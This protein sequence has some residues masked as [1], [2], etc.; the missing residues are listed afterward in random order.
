MYVE[1]QVSYTIYYYTHRHTHTHH[2]SLSLFIGRGKW[3]MGKWRYK[4]VWGDVLTGRPPWMY[5]Y[6]TVHVWIH[7]SN[8]FSDSFFLRIFFDYVILAFSLYS[9][10]SLF[11]CGKVSRISLFLLPKFLFFFKIIIEGLSLNI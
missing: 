5:M 7:M 4:G 8:L 3:K 2:I 9:L 1:T 11:Y 6:C 10:P